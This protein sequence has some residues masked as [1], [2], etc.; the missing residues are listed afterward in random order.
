MS[1]YT[2]D[3]ACHRS[4]VLQLVVLLCFYVI[5]R[6]DFALWF[7]V[8]RPWSRGPICYYRL[9]PYLK[10]Q[11]SAASNTWKPLETLFQ[12]T[13]QVFLLSSGEVC[14]SSITYLQSCRTSRTTFKDQFYYSPLCIREKKVLYDDWWSKDRCK[15]YRS[16]LQICVLVYSL[17]VLLSSLF[18]FVLMLS[19]NTWI[20]LW[21]DRSSKSIWKISSYSLRYRSTRM[22]DANRSWSCRYGLQCFPS[23]WCR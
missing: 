7:T 9:P 16:Y 5:S 6:Q 21:I 8:L 18:W 2:E 23:M 17:S 14:K 11:C 13:D 22:R 1:N 12:V 4:P 10:C 15:F 20:D 19:D 3:W